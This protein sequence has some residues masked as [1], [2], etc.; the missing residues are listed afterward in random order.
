MEV[1]SVSSVNWFIGQ[2][3]DDLRKAR[4]ESAVSSTGEFRAWARLSDHP[5]SCSK[6]LR[7]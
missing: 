7:S 4:R 5:S 3:K 6:H 1:R 2:V